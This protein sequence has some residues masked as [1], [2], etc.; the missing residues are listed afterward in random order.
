MRIAAKR[1]RER[2]TE[3]VEE[4]LARQLGIAVEEFRRIWPQMVAATYL[5]SLVELVGLV[6]STILAGGLTAF[7]GYAANDNHSEGWGMAA[8]ATGAVFLILVVIGIVSMGGILQGVFYPEAATVLR[9]L[10][11]V[12]SK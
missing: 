6:L 9:I 2:E 7:F 5:R 8:F 11:T 12:T 10:G 4:Q 3:F 1:V